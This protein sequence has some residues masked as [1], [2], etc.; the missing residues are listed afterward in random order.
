MLPAQLVVR[1]VIPAPALR[2]ADHPGVPWEAANEAPGLPAR[3]V[4]QLLA[5]DRVTYYVAASS[6]P[7]LTDPVS[8]ADPHGP[9]DLEEQACPTGELSPAPPVPRP[10]ASFRPVPPRPPV[11][12]SGPT[13][14]VRAS[15]ASR[16]GSWPAGPWP[17]RV[18]WA[19]AG[20][21]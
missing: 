21:A 12:S 8:L 17:T 4:R 16:T 9:L 5:P 7:G 13:S 3:A 14:T 20:S 2:L 1:A 15:Q 10:R 6:G 18:A 19:S 11:T